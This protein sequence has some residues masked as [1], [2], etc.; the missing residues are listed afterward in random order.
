MA[1]LCKTKAYKLMSNQCKL[2]D[3]SKLVV[4][5]ARVGSWKT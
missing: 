2:T 4:G 1:Q 5:L 3:D